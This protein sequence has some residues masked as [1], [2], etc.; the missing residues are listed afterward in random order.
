MRKLLAASLFAAALAG[1]T[2]SVPAQAQTA[3]SAQKVK[4]KKDKT[5]I[6][7]DDDTAARPEGHRPGGPG[8]MLVE[9]T[10]TLNLTA[11]QQTRVSAIQQEQMQQMQ[12]L[13]EQSSAGTDRQAMM[14]QMRS[15]DETTD[16]QLKAVLTPEQFQK[17]QAQKQERMRNRRLPG[18]NQ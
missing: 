4:T 14:T 2:L 9:M 12:T 18:A 11:D 13:R 15:L 1:A 8:N 10:K 16:T 5:K 7:G 6:K 17:Y 3:P